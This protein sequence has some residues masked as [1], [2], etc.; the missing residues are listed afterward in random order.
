VVLELPDVAEL[1]GDEL[2][3]GEQY[4]RAEEDRAVGRVAVETAEPR[5]Q[6]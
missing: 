2:L 6:E 4:A 3:V 5:K 1:V